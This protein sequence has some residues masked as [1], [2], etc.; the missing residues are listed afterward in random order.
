M[1]IGRFIS[2]L[3]ITIGSVLL[4]VV[5]LS[6]LLLNSTVF[7]NFLRSEIRKQAMQRLGL[8]VDIGALE[9]DWT[10]LGLQLNDVVVHGNENAGEPPLL[11]ATSLALSVRFLPLFEGHVHLGELIVRRPIV[12]VRIARDGSSNVVIAPHA[13]RGGGDTVARIFD[14]KVENCAIHGGEVYYNDAETPLDAELHD[15]RF[16]ATYRSLTGKYTGLLSYDNGRLKTARIRPV[17]HAIRAEF[18]AD[19]SGLSLDSLSL[20]IG[21]AS[22]L[23]LRATI[24]DYAKPR[25]EGAYQANL[26]LDDVSRALRLGAIPKGEVALEGRF[27]YDSSAPGPVMRE[28][29]LEG[30]AHSE[31]L[32]LK[33]PQS[34]PV[35]GV[36]AAYELKEAKLAVT[37]FSATVLG[38]QVRASWEMARVD[39]PRPSEQLAASLRGVSLARAGDALTARE[40]QR[41]PIVGTANLDVNASWAGSLD[42]AIAHLRLAVAGPPQALNSPSVIPVSG[43]LEAYYDGPRDR[44]SFGQSYLQTTSTRLSITGMLSPRPSGN[45]NI[46][47]ELTS[48][49]LREVNS[50]AGLIENAWPSLEQGAKS[51]PP[52]GGSASFRGTVTGTAKDPRV[53][54]EL[55]AQNLSVDKSRWK[56][57]SLH[58]EAESSSIRIENGTLA[59]N[60]RGQITLSGTAGLEHWSIV[61]SSPISFNAKAADISIEDAEKIAQLHYPITGTMAANISVKGTK[62]NP[63]TDGTMTLTHASAWNEPI[64]RLTLNAQSNQGTI[65]STARLEV[66]AGTI[67]AEGT[68]KLTNQQYTCEVHGQGLQLEKI[69]ALERLLSAGGKAELSAMGNGTIEDPSFEANLTIPQLQIRDQSISNVAAQIGIARHHATLKLNSTVYNGSVEAKG[70]VNMTGSRYATVRV[71]VRSLPIE[72]VLATFLTTEDSK[73]SGQTE[74]H[75]S[76]QGPL[77]TPAQI[78]AHLEIPTLYLAYQNAQLALARPLRADYRNGEIML[79]P[80]QIQGTGTNLTF[81]GSVPIRNPS[82]RS[83]LSADGSMDLSVLRQFA[84]DV[85]SSGQLI[86]HLRGNGPSLA[87]VHGQFEVRN[88][89]LS[90]DSVPVGVEGLNAQINLSGTRADIVNCAGSVGGGTISARGFVSYE[91]AVTFNL[92]MNANSVRIRYPEG[93]RSILSGQLNLQGTPSRSSLTGKVL[94]DRMSF[95]QAFDL[96]NFAGDFSQASSG[97]TP[98]QLERGMQLNIAV[99]SAQN[100][101]LTSSKVSVGGSANLMVRGTLADPVVLGRVTLTSGEVFF[102]GKR[103]EVQSGTV[104]FANLVR[105]EPVLNLHVTTRIE[106]YNVTLSLSGPI[107]RLKTSYTSDPALPEADII[108]LL[109]FGNTTEEAAAAPSR[110]FGTSAESVLAQGVSSQVAGKVENVTGISQLTIDPLAANV[111][112]NPGAQVALQERVTGSL[113]LTFTTDVTSTQAQTVELQYQMNKRWSVTVLRDQNGGYGID[114][115]LHKEF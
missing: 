34:L 59:E 80:T 17:E 107:E 46:S 3:I 78:E 24:L 94:V 98:S 41:I 73:I 83:S 81:S 47:I 68:Y 103:F 112:R 93:L 35:T 106:Q 113:L 71:D 43:L 56:S 89:V 10:R 99:Q 13:P 18:A 88:A 100:L 57:L 96:A 55:A 70:D 101:N 75:L 30:S 11:E 6:V 91:H 95:T 111:Q 49:D 77:M 90:S 102:L 27:R 115:R 40:M 97:A 32:N 38:A 14:L 37:D 20:S 28:V 36:R 16:Q 64:N 33:S 45:S 51:I 61:S 19:R 69:S 105:T 58:L 66:P 79:A 50:L 25:I 82:A 109:A 2:R 62:E 42:N 104:A 22:R 110:G 9:T 67:S 85:R 12:H 74:I 63:E 86:L 65:Q 108:H 76:M 39:S 87:G 31:R 44:V 15:L 60:P 8:R 52:L 1:S 72:H 21:E 48:S 84:T 23:T 4:G 92:A 114:V 54:G 53:Q 29:Q 26:L 5:V 7:R